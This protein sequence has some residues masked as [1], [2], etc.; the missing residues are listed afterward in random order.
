MKDK[1]TAVVKE[2]W[3]RKQDNDRKVDEV[4]NEKFKEAFGHYPDSKT[5]KH[6][7]GNSATKRH[8]RRKK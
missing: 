2:K 3:L 5:K 4:F 8:K 1:K 7:S 6:G